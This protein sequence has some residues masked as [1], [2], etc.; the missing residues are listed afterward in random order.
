MLQNKTTDTSSSNTPEMKDTEA[1]RSVADIISAS[2]DLARTSPAHSDL[3]AFL[4]SPLPE[5]LEDFTT[6]PL[7]DD[8]LFSDFDTSPLL[9]TPLLDDFGTSPI[10]DSPFISDLHTPI[11]SV[12]DDFGLGFGGPLIDDGAVSMYQG[13]QEP[14]KAQQPTV[15]SSNLVKMSPHTPALG[16][17]TSPSFPMS[18]AFPPTPASSNASLPSTIAKGGKR[19]TGTRRNITPSSLVPFDAPTQPRRYLTPSA[20]SRKDVPAVFA[21]KRVRTSLSSASASPNLNADELGH[22]FTPEDE[23]PD[24]LEPLP[25]NATEAQIIEHKR[26]QNTLAARKSRKRKLEHQQLLEQRNEALEREVEM[27]KVRC[28]VLGGL[29][30]GVGV[31]V[32]GMDGVDAPR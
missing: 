24:E 14:E 10:D 19:P 9:D 25:P 5:L 20:T 21:R 28:G 6:S 17:F 16:N 2:P 12:H 3:N 13:L 18:H 30:R 26:R 4:T 23:Q 1:M 31:D 11:I 32:T 8:P 27:W 22:S 15:D 7:F 29:L